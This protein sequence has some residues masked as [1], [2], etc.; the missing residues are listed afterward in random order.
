[1]LMLLHLMI[2]EYNIRFGCIRCSVG[3]FSFSV[4]DCGCGDDDD[5]DDTCAE[6]QCGFG[7]GGSVGH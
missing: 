7:G 4:N 2:A 6:S 1:M 5:D 3:S